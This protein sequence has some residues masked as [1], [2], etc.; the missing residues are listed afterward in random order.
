MLRSIPVLTVV[1]AASAAFAPPS[2]T[3]PGVLVGPLDIAGARSRLQS[4][5]EPTASFFQAAAASSQ[6]KA[7]Y[8]PFGPPANGTISCG[9]YDKPNIGCSDED[10]DVDAA[11][12][13]ALL[14][15]LGGDPALAGSARSIINLYSAGLLRYTNNTE[16]TCCGNEAL[17][18]AWVSAKITRAAELLRHTPGSGWT[19]ADTAAFNRLMYDVHLPHLYNGTQSNGNWMASFVEVREVGDSQREL[20]PRDARA[21]LSNET[22]S[23]RAS[24]LL[25]LA[26]YARHRDLLRE[27]DSLRARAGGVA[28]AHAEL[29]VHHERRRCSSTEPPAQL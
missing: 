7:T 24:L 25:W 17:Q 19:D 29:L 22:S 13:Q 6:G 26:G 27:R 12:T 5:I 18:A 20:T 28:G 4:G 1:A 14:F 11:Y 2:W 10:S 8:K 9:Y 15:A 3:H 21:E 16:G 23:P